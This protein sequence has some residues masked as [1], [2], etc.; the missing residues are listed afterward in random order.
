M[1]VKDRWT[2]ELSYTIFHFKKEILKFN[3]RF[4]KDYSDCSMRIELK[5][6]SNFFQYFFM[7]TTNSVNYLLLKQK[8]FN[9]FKNFFFI[10]LHLLI[11]P[12]VTKEPKN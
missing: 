5:F 3:Y 1:V 7:K 6:N 9:Y 12:F 10:Y 11:I 8:V 2:H 4:T